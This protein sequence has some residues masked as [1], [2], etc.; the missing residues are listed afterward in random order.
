MRTEVKIQNN[1]TVTYCKVLFRHHE[2][3]QE[4]FHSQ[5]GQ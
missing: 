3:N 5:D 1:A 2:E 4:N